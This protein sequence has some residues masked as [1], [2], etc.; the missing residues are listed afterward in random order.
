MRRKEEKKK[1]KILKG[2]I[3]TIVFILIAIVCKEAI[4]KYSREATVA[5]IEG[6]VVVFEDWRGHHWKWEE[7]K[8]EKKY[9][10]HEK[11]ILIFHDNHTREKIEDDVIVEI[12]RK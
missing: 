9:S 2:V 5:S 6:N 11:V 12:K 1:I 10:K 8:E 7:E 4:S 3:F